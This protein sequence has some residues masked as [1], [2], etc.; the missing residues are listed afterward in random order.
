[1]PFD[2]A[3]QLE[4][5]H[6]FF[7]KGRPLV[8]HSA[9][10]HRHTA[11][12][13]LNKR[14]KLWIFGFVLAMALSFALNWRA[15]VFGIII[16][17]TVFYFA[18]L[19]FNLIL[20]YRSFSR[21]PEISVSETELAALPPETL[22]L[23][24][25][26]CPLYREWAVLPQFIKAMEGLDYPKDRLQIMLLLEEDDTETIAH[27]RRASLASHFE[28]VVVP[29]S[30]PKTKPK[31]MN[32]GLKHAR[33]EYITI[34]DAEDVPEPGQLKKAVAAFRRL[35]PEVIC[36]QGKLNFYNPNQNFVTKLF[37]AEYSLWF[38]L[39]LPGMQSFN[40]PIPLGG[41]SNHFRTDD[42]RRLNGWDAFNVTEDCD[43]GMRLAKYGHNTAIMESTTYEE[44]NSDL[45]NWYRQRSRWIKG[46]MQTYL[47]HMRFPKQ[48]WRNWREPH[49]L[50]FQMVV[51]GKILSMF[52]NPFLWLV[53]IIYFAFRS[54]AAPYI[55]PFF[56]G[57]ILYLGVACLVFGN[58]LYLYYYMVGLAKRGQYG[59]IKYMFIVPFYWL[60]MSAAAWKAL[61]E[62][63]VKPHYWAK[64][65]HGL[66]INKKQA[67]KELREAAIAAGQNAGLPFAG[68]RA[69]AGDLLSG[70]VGSGGVLVMAMV[71]GNFLNLL[72]NIILGRSLTLEDFATVTLYNTILNILAVVLVALGSSVNYKVSFLSGR[73]N[74]AAANNFTKT[75]SRGVWWTAGVLSLLWIALIPLFARF[76]HVSNFLL[77]FSFTPVI[78]LSG[79]AAVFNGYLRGRFRFAL[80][81]Q[82]IILEA[83]AKTAAAAFLV[84]LGLRA[85]ASLAIPV[86]VLVSFTG[87]WV[88]VRYVKSRDAK[89]AAEPQT[90]RGSREA[91]PS[92][93]FVATMVNGLASAVFLNADVL[94]A[95]HYLDPAAAGAYALLSLAGKMVYLTGTLLSPFLVSIVGRHEGAGTN[96]R[97]DFYKLLG[98]TALAGGGAFAFL[99]VFGKHV[100]P[101]LFG[102]RSLV[103]LP[104]LAPYCL[105]MALFALTGMVIS[106]HVVK[107]QY[108][109]PLLMLACSSFLVAGL[110][111]SHQNIASFTHIMLLASILSFGLIFGWH[112][113][114]KNSEFLWR[115]LIDLFGA[116]T[117][118]APIQVAAGA[119]KILIFNWRDTKHVFAGGAEVY[120][121][122][123][124]KRWV[125]SGN[126]VTLFCG[127]DGRQPRAEIIDGIHIV[128]RGG[129]YFVYIWA[130]LYYLLQFRGKYD[131]ILDCHNGIPFFA[132]LFSREKV[133]CLMHH[134]HQQVFYR[135]LWWPLARFA[136]FL[137]KTIMPLVYRRTKFITV[138]NSSKI[139][140]LELGLGQ[141]GLEI[142]H[143][144]VDLGE[145]KSG[146]KNRTPLI[147]YLG[148]LKAYKSVDVLIRAFHRVLGREPQARLVIAGDGEDR[149]RLEQLS[150]KLGL[151]DS[152]SFTGAVSENDKISLLKKAWVFCNP[153]LMEGWGITTIEAN[154]CGV[155]VV[156]ADVPGLRDSVRNPH[157]GYLVEHGNVEGFAEKITEI[158]KNKN[159]RDLMGKKSLTWA[160][161]FDWDKSAA[162]TLNVL[163]G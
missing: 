77:I 28:I 65:V 56:P 131:V 88:F 51:G 31:A 75:V 161:N 110:A 136:A 122:E 159:L 104:F 5:G 70:G 34:Y 41:T 112:F 140:I 19:V 121:T 45:K 23:Y 147:L 12:E 117:P 144:G 79:I 130:Y 163:Y 100:I 18:D 83:L 68:L 108:S 128:R 57:W 30:L 4:K 135:H 141:E 44:A 60:A 123:L 119:K 82:I 146:R 126:H 71:A 49:L 47:V 96:S 160:K 143:P 61:Y 73:N 63:V 127:N 86:S 155:P 48:F 103:I 55:E 26:F 153:S 158:L 22:P 46:Y 1:M 76:F 142:V 40:A 91:F 124:A 3:T 102:A 107:R 114:R 154:A 95:K 6:G 85:W 64:T 152:V 81:G 162:H 89:S 62:I 9:L 148:R 116:F 17:L 24:T 99:A 106:Y 8:S 21:R 138:S 105:A 11:F 132:P 33:G 20:I 94:L 139:D 32:Y 15:T 16:A 67:K 43:L 129:F 7:Y 2:A 59:L 93:Y 109:F 98:G 72:F 53:T 87:T 69:R 52:I 115:A 10:H 66:H 150:K 39:V 35:G 29:H 118:M 84:W 151:E 37:T 149:S 113:T 50:T 80:F 78:A 14:Q 134:V 145:L 42:L 36:I 120:V 137:E 13:T 38:D 58:F 90:A 92:W 125:A 156:A 157:T 111:I 25:I 101:L 97:P 74:I 133:Y 54:Q 27:A